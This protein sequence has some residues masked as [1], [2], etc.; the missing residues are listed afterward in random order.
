MNAR[1]EIA[2]HVRLTSGKFA[3][4]APICFEV[5]FRLLVMLATPRCSTWGVSLR[6]TGIAEQALRENA[7]ATEWEPMLLEAAIPMLSSSMTSS[8]SS[9]TFESPLSCG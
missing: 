7:R 1:P 4:E 8:A 3:L 6:S 2:M 5:L 9:E